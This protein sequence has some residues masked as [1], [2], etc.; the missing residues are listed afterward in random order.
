MIM[1]KVLMV[2]DSAVLLKIAR[3]TLE[4]AGHTVIE[5]HN[6]VEAVA[7]CKAE[8]PNIIFMDAEMPEMDG[9]E[10]CRT[11]KNDPETKSTPVYIYT[12]HEL[13]GEDEQNFMAAGANGV[14]QK[15]YKP[16]EMLE[17]I[18]KAS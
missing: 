2:D 14:L 16:P 7:L 18:A 1:A 8:K 15:P 17:R 11:I 13:G 6:G 9:T 3:M 12:G 4:K 5:G 10:A